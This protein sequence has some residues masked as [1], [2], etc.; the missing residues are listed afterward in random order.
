MKRYII[1]FVLV[2]LLTACPSPVLRWIETPGDYSGLGRLTGQTGIKEIISFSFGIDGEKDLPIGTDADISGKIP[3][4]VILPEGTGLTELIP[5]VTYIGKSLNPPSGKTGDF[6]S[7]VVYTVTAEDSTTQ[8]YI[9]RV[10]KKGPSTKEIIRLTLDVFRN[11]GSPLGAEGIIDQNA[12]VVTVTVPAGTPLT[13]LT[14]HV[15]HIGA[16]VTG[17]QGHFHPDETF[18][19]HGDFTNPTTWTVHARDESTKIY[20]LFV[21]REKD[22]AKE[23]T[24]FSLGNPGET[25]IIGGEPRSD[26]VYPIVAL[27]PDTFTT[28]STAPFISYKGA[29]ISPGTDKSL[30]FNTPV[31]YTVSA[32]D[33]TTRDYEVQIIRRH[34]DSEKLIT[35]FYFQNPLVA[36]VI[37]QVG[38]TIALTVP[39]GTNLSALRPEIYYKGVSVSPMSGQPRGFTWATSPISSSPYVPYTVLGGDGTTETY[40]VYVFPDSSVPP[41][42]DVPAGGTADVG[43]DASGNPLVFVEFP[44]Y[45]YN[46]KIKISYPGAGSAA[47]T[48]VVNTGNTYNYYD[49]SKNTSLNMNV[50][51]IVINPP[52]NPSAP[53]ADSGKAQIDA[54]YFADPAAIGAIGTTGTGT[55]T[56]PI[57]IAVTVPFGTDRRNLTATICYTG[58]EI[59]GHPGANPIKDTGSFDS[60]VT[61]TVNPSSGDSKTYT[62]NV[63]IQDNT[64][65]EITDL[66]LLDGTSPVDTNVIISALPNADGDYPIDVTVPISFASKINA[67][68]PVI[69]HTGVSISGTNI[70]SGGTGTVTASAAVDFTSAQVYTVTA[71]DTTIDPKKY[72]V[73]VHAATFDDEP[74]IL[75][76]YFTSPLAVGV[77]N[78]N[79]YAITVTVPPGTN[80]RALAPT[81]YFKGVSVRPG[82][83]AVNNFDSP[84]VYTVTGSTGKTKSYLVTVRPTPSST[85]DITRF[86]FPAI[87]GAETIIGAAPDPDGIYPLAVWVPA[88]TALGGIAPVISHTGVSINPGTGT[89]R[90]FNVPQTYTVTAEDGSVKT[91]RV[92]VNALDTNAKILTSFVFNEVPLGTSPYTGYVRAVGSIDQDNRKVTVMVPYAA[93]VAKLI[94]TL[95]YVGRSVTEPGAG[96]DQTANP[97]TGAEQNFGASKT[98]TVKDQSGGGVNYTVTVLKQS[99]ADVDFD[100]EKDIVFASS[101][102]NQETGVITV[103]VD[104]GKIDGP[105]DWYLDGVKQAAAGENFTLNVGNGFTPGRHEIMVSGRKNGLHYTGKVY[106]TVS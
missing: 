103:M 42:V 86:G 89:V 4:L 34:E 55:P 9:V 15:T 104:K 35:G 43:V 58:K 77:V 64:A 62:V 93:D 95:T 36:G 3:I 26:G 51:M 37:D 65:K 14:A 6:S 101:V 25:D 88:G 80:T 48:Q 63:E 11:G 85:K 29:A 98:Y 56:D 69:T 75:G 45:I 30:D 39:A 2:S 41:T 13:G 19:F 81:L 28:A 57:P 54:F 84:V 78:Q 24:K 38:H 105:Y 68:T 82:S 92:T 83:G 59:A 97:F 94:P 90:D 5:Q 79:T 87:P 21:V 46:P 60:S 17:P 67:L 99:A 72:T 7:P 102:F 71:E 53:P 23:I 49:Y 1:P 12:G 96:G 47:V 31:R 52:A 76:F 18:S 16:G 33:G 74:E 10:Y 40:K 20:T 50:K 70:S 27:V 73:V 66:S 32:E 91:Y 22:G 106:F 61:Y 100:G 8:D 44:A